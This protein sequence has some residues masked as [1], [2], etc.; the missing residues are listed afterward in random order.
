M[1][2]DSEEAFVD[3]TNLLADPRYLNHLKAA[4]HKEWLKF[5]YEGG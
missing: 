5:L 1:T 4:Q 2:L 3:V